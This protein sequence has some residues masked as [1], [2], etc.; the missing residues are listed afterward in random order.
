MRKKYHLH[1]NEVDYMQFSRKM[2]LRLSGFNYNIFFKSIEDP[3]ECPVSVSRCWTL[4]SFPNDITS[5]HQN[6][7]EQDERKDKR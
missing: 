6:D 1:V 7:A 5:K 2:A 4:F 3:C